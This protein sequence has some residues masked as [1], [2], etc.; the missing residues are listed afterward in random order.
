ERGVGG[1]VAVGLCLDR[2]PDL[3]I[4]LL[5]VLKAG[6]AYLPL[7]PAYPAARRQ[8]MIDDARVEIVLS[9][10]DLAS[11][12]PQGDYRRVLVDADASAIAACDDSPLPR[13]ATPRN[14]A[15]IIY[16]SGSTGQPKG[17][18]VEHRGLVNHA[19]EFV[20]LYEM[21]P[22]DRLL[23][24]LSLSFDAAA[25]EIFPALIS[26]A[27]LYLHPQPA[28]LSGR[29][30]LKWT[31]AHRVNLLHVPPAVW[32]SLVDEANGM[33]GVSARHLKCVVSGGDNV[34]R[35]HVRRFRQA[36]GGVK[37]VLAYGVTEATI[38]TTVCDGAAPIAHSASGRLPIGRPIANNRAYVLDECG[39][40]APIGVPGELVVGGV[41]VARGYRGRP[42]ATIAKFG[43]D[44][45]DPREGARIY[46]TG[47]LARFLPDGN[48]EFLGRLD[49]QVK[50]RGYRV[51]PGEI[52]AALNEHEQVVESI[53]VP[54]SDGET[55]RLAA[56]V[57]CGSGPLP[58]ETEL[59]AFLASRLPAHMSPASLTILEH[60]PHL[61]G[62]KVDIRALPA[63]CWQRG[64]QGAEYAAPRN[65]VERRLA[66]IWQEVLGLDRVGVHDNFFDL[67]GDSIRSIQVVARAGAAGLR[68][69]PKQLFQNQSI[70]ELAPLVG[71]APVA[72]A[73]QGPVVGVTP[74]TPIQRQ[75]F[76]LDLAEPQHFNQSLF[77]EVRPPVTFEALAQAT[78][79]LLGHHDALRMRYRRLSSG[80]WEQ[81]CLPPRDANAIEKDAGAS[82]SNNAALLRIDLS[83]IPDA[84][85]AAAI[86]H[87][88]AT[89]QASLDLEQGRLTRFVYFDL[90][91]SRPAR[92]LL[93]IHHLVMDAVSWRILF[94]DLN[95]LCEQIAHGQLPQLPPKTTAVRDWALRLIDYAE[96]DEVR[97]ELAAWTADAAETR[98]LPCDLTDKPNTVATQDTVH[99]ELSPEVTQRLLGETSSD[100]RARPQELLVAALAQVV[101]RY[102]GGDAVT[103]D[104]E[105]HGREDLFADVDLSRT[106]GWFTSVY[107]LTLR[108]PDLNQP[109]DWVRAIKEQLRA[110]RNSGVGYNALRWLCADET[111]R[112]RLSEAPRPEIAFN[113]L[114][115]FDNLSP[116]DA[117]FYLATE[118]HGAEH[119]PRGARPHLW[120]VN[121]YIHGGRFQVS[122]IYSRVRHRRETIERLAAQYLAELTRFT[123][124]S[125]SPGVVVATP[126]D[127]PLADIDQQDLDQLA[128]LLGQED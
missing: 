99:V 120:E 47:D 74:L 101:T 100:F 3:I 105:G 28:E 91:P 10:S 57:G 113:Y 122:W 116:P 84:E 119:S 11:Q 79:M 37:F 42:D 25:E 19:S 21:G 107:P 35:E 60:L 104:L 54:H 76:A 64:E 124:A 6:G 43:P 2:S 65:D 108:R 30:L 87:H 55:K 20:R 26:G 127:F 51:E 5:S 92:L 88:G 16:T 89:A 45:F 4:A 48:L 39:Q 9:R 90:G 69:T 58:S 114:G 117:M 59:R 22:G 12:L 53:V 98:S 32:A 77:L 49:L 41:G 82:A 50:I 95:L 63:P 8:Y 103:F 86:D 56:Y 17:V 38:T 61:P 111:A 52:E 18:E 40:P 34:P 66:E 14:L 125:R 7:D 27:T 102:A 94:A 83:P 46:H 31:L 73:E 62:A 123:E 93:V 96:S 70:G 71:T 44:P 85:L 78:A 106:V 33:A 81:E 1:D 80:E 112:R 24:Y 109:V 68:F 67:G 118:P 72:C 13:R 128:A 29:E 97:G 126:T 110:V 36:T 15:Y 75:F 23:F 115:Q 121:A